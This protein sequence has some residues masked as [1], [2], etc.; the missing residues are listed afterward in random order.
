MKIV[1]VGGPGAGKTILAGVMA[2][3][4]AEDDQR[5]GCARA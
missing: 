2:T 4:F 3:E 5:S 1:I